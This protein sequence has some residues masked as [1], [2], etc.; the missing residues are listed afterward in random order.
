VHIVPELMSRLSLDPEGVLTTI[1]NALREVQQLVFNELNDFPVRPGV[2]CRCQPSRRHIEPAHTNRSAVALSVRRRKQPC[3]PRTPCTPASRRSTGSQSTSSPTSPPS[4]PRTR[5]TSSRCGHGRMP[6]WAVARLGAASS[7]A[8][9]DE[10]A[11][12]SHP[13]AHVG[14]SQVTGTVVRT[15]QVRMVERQRFFRCAN[16]RCG[17]LFAVAIEVEHDNNLNMPRVCPSPAP[18]DSG[19]GGLMG[20]E[21]DG[22]GDDGGSRRGGG[23]S[24]RRGGGRGGG[25][26]GRSGGGPRKCTST[27]FTAVDPEEAAASGVTARVTTDYQEVKIQA[28]A[29]AGGGLHPALHRRRARGRPRGR[30]QSG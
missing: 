13:C 9:R 25:R 26:G 20:D 30:R 5:A 18:E 1:E 22:G 17:W 3:A 2:G 10:V 11:Q 29:V 27:V 6:D 16:E 15:G 28:R 7:H 19:D 14:P 4:G 24:W 23:R 21:G 8:L 12:S